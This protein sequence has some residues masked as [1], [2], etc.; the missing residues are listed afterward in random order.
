MSG[1]R[2]TKVSWEDLDKLEDLTDWERVRS[3]TDEEIAAAAA[4]DPDTVHPDDPWWREQMARGGVLVPPGLK[5]KRV[6]LQLDEDVVAW[7]RR[8]GRGWQH[9]VNHVL[10]RHMQDEERRQRDNGESAAD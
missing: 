10:R 5:K 2:I 3:M 7:F 8:Q 1:K 9:G 6:T 4:D